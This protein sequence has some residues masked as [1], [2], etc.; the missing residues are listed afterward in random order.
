MARHHCCCFLFCTS[1][2]DEAAN[3]LARHRRRGR[4]LPGKSRRS[5][6][7]SSLSPSGAPGTLPCSRTD[8]ERRWRALGASVASPSRGGGGASLFGLWLSGRQNNPAGS[9][10]EQLQFAEGT[11]MT[12]SGQRCIM[13]SVGFCAFFCGR[14][15][16]L[17]LKNNKKSASDRGDSH[18]GLAEGLWKGTLRDT[19]HIPKHCTHS[20]ASLVYS[21]KPA[22]LYRLNPRLPARLRPGSVR[23]LH[24]HVESRSY[25][26]THTWNEGHCN[27]N[28]LCVC[29]LSLSSRLEGVRGQSQCGFTH[30]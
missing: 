3:Q 22:A 10:C 13:G 15:A 7:G 6:P 28:R 9:S 5:H 29:L 27:K 12:Q 8:T 26:H 24:C 18:T 17:V 14:G 21:S 23:D 30:R 20:Y 2:T 11:P 19:P 4:P 25:I 1:R 16:Q